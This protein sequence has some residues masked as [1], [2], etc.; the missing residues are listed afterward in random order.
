MRI[1]I[2]FIS[3]LL[4]LLL[5]LPIV[6]VVSAQGGA[7]EAPSPTPLTNVLENETGESTVQVVP[8]PQDQTQTQLGTQ[9][10]TI[11]DIRT[12]VTPE[13]LVRISWGAIIAGVIVA[14]VL[15]LALNLLGL[16]IGANAINPAVGRDTA[17]PD[18]LGRNALLWVGVTTIIALFFGGWVAGR[19][20][21]LPDNTDGLVHGLITWALVTLITFYLL[22]TRIGALVSG[23]SHLFERF[24][25]V[26][27]VGAATVAQ[28]A[29]AVTKGAVNVTQD[30]AR[31]AGHAAQGVA[32]EAKHAAQNVADNVGGGTDVQM[33]D[34]SLDNIKAEARRLME[35][36][37]VQPE[38]VQASAGDAVQQVKNTAQ[39]IAQDPAHARQEIDELIQRLFAIGQ[40]A[41]QSADRDTLINALVE[42]AGVSREEAEQQI[43]RWQSDLDQARAQAERTLQQTKAQAERK[44]EDA[45]RQVQQAAAEAE[46][47]AREA[48]QTATDTISKAAAA[49]FAAMVIG[50]IAAG[51]GGLVGTP[52]EL[53]IV[54]IDR[55][56]DNQ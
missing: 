2:Y 19:M 1:R 51:I 53:P 41:T 10:N 50:A 32:R 4:V 5:S 49:I 35:R 30:V 6:A 15:Q 43:D 27:G 46:Y 36:A 7:Q 20:A 34:I 11:P 42:R 25:S 31:E 8:L 21:G 33:P 47:K 16:S 38:Q 3:L 17:E 52:D 39:A 29:V 23:I 44:V 45:K 54:S 14:L 12:A 55:T 37:G 24:L 13:S 40:T 18:E 9:T 48:A 28:G 22:T 56:A 26:V